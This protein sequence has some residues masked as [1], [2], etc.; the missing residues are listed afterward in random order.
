MSIVG[1]PIPH[2][3]A[4]APVTGAALY[5][6]DLAQRLPGVLH[7]W[8]AMAPHAHAWLDALDTTAARAVPGVV[9]VLTAADVPGENDTGASRRDEPLFP[10]PPAADGG[11]ARPE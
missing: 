5:T 8:P 7:A 1:R 6:D 9:L 2:E 10:R 4:D 11:E 3:S